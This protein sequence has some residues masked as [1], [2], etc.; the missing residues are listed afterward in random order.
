[1]LKFP[2]GLRSFF[3]ISGDPET[4]AERATCKHVARNSAWDPVNFTA[5]LLGFIYVEF[6]DYRLFGAGEIYTRP[7]MTNV[8]LFLRSIR[9][10]KL[11]VM[12]YIR[13]KST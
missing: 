12:R 6:V 9:C 1:M 11:G 3:S 5:A 8:T 7:I 13:V 2:V 10:K 4:R